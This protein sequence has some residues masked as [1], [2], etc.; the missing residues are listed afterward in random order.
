MCRSSSWQIQ[1]TADNSIDEAKMM[2]EIGKFAEGIT[3]NAR[4]AGTSPVIED[5]QLVKF[6]TNLPV[7][8]FV[9]KTGFRYRLRNSS[10]LFEIAK[11]QQFTASG[12]VLGCRSSDRVA[13]STTWGASL[14]NEDWDIIL[15]QNAHLGIGEAG[16]WKPSLTRFFPRDVHT[17]T[18]GPEAGFRN[19][20]TEVGKVATLLDPQSW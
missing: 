4:P 11:Y 5:H 6:P 19:F 2:P 18:P 15:G 1:L 14:F 17:S 7:R 10:Y 8:A 20:L 16:N 3:F 13:S 12:S 9:Q